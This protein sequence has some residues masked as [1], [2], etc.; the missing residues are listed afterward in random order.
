MKQNSSSPQVTTTLERNKNCGTKPTYCRSSPL[1]IRGF[2]L[3]KSIWTAWVCIE[4]R[5]VLHSV[6]VPDTVCYFSYFSNYWISFV[7]NNCYFTFPKFRLYIW[8]C[9]CG[10][11]ICTYL[12]IRFNV[13]SFHFSK[14]HYIQLGS[15]IYSYI[16]PL[17]TLI[18]VIQCL[19]WK[20]G[21]YINLFTLQFS[22]RIYVL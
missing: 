19:F 5:M 21:G 1:S 15:L 10:L 18:W 22:A 9:Y 7:G 6:K 2:P 20:Y 13:A 16:Q 17:E 11:C 4:R 12:H 3:H 14:I 8:W